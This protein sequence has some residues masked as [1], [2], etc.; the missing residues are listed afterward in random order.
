[1]KY[2]HPLMRLTLLILSATAAWATAAEVDLSRLSALKLHNVKADLVNYRGRQA[3]EV[4]GADALTGSQRPGHLVIVADDFSNGTIEVTLAGQPAKDAG[5]AARGF[6]GVA[7]RVQADL[8]TYDAFYLRPTNGRADDQLRRN[9]AVQYISHPEHTWNKL[10]QATP[11]KYETY[12]DLVP[13]EWT[14]V[15][16]EV[17]GDRARLFVHDATQPT[18]IVNGLL[19]GKER[20]AVALW[21]EGSTLAHFTNL[22][23]TAH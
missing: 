1:M 19:S 9:H 12:V 6:V 13:G 2:S 8:E 20:G 11:G 23:I 3:L 4:S 22:S 21:I 7:F 18:L 17:D 14:R 5:S 10:R 16:I 15:R